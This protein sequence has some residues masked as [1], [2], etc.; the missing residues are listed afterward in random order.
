[1]RGVA[2]ARVGFTTNCA[3]VTAADENGPVR[4]GTSIGLRSDRGPVLLAAMLAT[5]LIAIDSTII[6]TAVPSIV[7]D[8]G[9]FTEFPWLFSCYLL[10]QAVTVPVYGKLADLF[11]RRPVL[12]IGIGVFLVGSVLCGLAWAMP[13]LIA[14]R[15]VQGLGAGAIQPMAVTI[16]GD[17]YTTA[18][19]ARVQGYIASVWAMSSVVGPTLGGLLSEYASWRWIFLINVP[20]CLITAALVVKKFAERVQRGRPRIDVRGSVLLTA[21]LTLAL[22]A[23]LEGGQAWAWLSPAGIAITGGAVVL[24]TVF[25]LVE[26]KAAEP[27]LPLWVFKRR[28]LVVSGIIAVG[29]GAIWLGLSSYVPTY[30]QVVLGHGPLVAGLAVGALLLGWPAAASQSGRIF[31]RFGFRVC[32]VLGTSLA[33]IG[34]A[35][36]LTLDEETPVLLVAAFCAF[37]GLGMGFTVAPTVIASQSSVGWSERGVVTAANMF[38][39][40]TGSAV[41]VAVFGAIA[42]ATVGSRISEVAGTAVDPDLLSVAMVRIA[43]VM[44]LLAVVMLVA[45]TRIPARIV[46]QPRTPDGV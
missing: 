35:F 13:V 28:L 40:S 24:L 45:A 17:L 20:L 44:V 34:S 36:L 11:G 10:A 27:V 41:G 4:T 46:E 31:L 42:N 18:E 5:A 23:I 16:V 7:A 43:A 32:V 14:A 29:A 12:L 6:S 21:G 26:R 25:V 38:L 37:I 39:R 2:R 33:V 3:R 9:G 8:I 15:V 22:L 19:R 1:M 30:V